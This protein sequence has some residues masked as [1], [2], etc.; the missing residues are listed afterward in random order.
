MHV[1]HRGLTAGLY[2]VRTDDMSDVDDLIP[3]ELEDD[4][5]VWALGYNEPLDIDNIKEWGP[6]LMKPNTCRL[7][8]GKDVEH[9]QALVR[10]LGGVTLHGPLPFDT[11][12][13]LW[14]AAAMLS[15]QYDRMKVRAEAAEMAIEMA[16]DASDNGGG[17]ASDAIQD[18]LGILR[19][20]D[21]EEDDEG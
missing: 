10:E 1:S 15:N 8:E 11:A 18:M 4:G 3:A 21:E 12:M 14:N 17:S 20:D 13:K 6:E 7:P 16:I 2:W 9:A 19:R 5:K